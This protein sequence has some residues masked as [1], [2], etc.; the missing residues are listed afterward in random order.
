MLHRVMIR[1]FGMANILIVDDSVPDAKI[2]V[3][4]TISQKKW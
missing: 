1:S 3:I 2:I 4:Y